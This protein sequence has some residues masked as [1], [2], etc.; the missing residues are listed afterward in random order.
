MACNRTAHAGAMAPSGALDPR[1]GDARADF[2]VNLT[3]GLAA[4][5]FQKIFKR[6]GV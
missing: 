5:H 6:D 2:T 1:S 3:L 4:Q